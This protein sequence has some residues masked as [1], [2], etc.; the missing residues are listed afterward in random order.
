MFYQVRANIYFKDED[1]ANDFYDDCNKALAKGNVINPGT[2]EQ[3]FSSIEEIHCAHD[4]FPHESC[5]PLDSD[6]NCPP[7]PG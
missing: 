2:P 5:Y 4:E 3:E 6:D 1:E 7:V